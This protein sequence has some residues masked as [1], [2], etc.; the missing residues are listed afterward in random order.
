VTEEKKISYMIAIYGLMQKVLKT[1]KLLDSK[2]KPLKIKNIEMHEQDAIALYDWL[3]QS[4]RKISE[5]KL[6]TQA[7]V[8]NAVAKSLSNE[9]WLNLYLLALFM[10]ESLLEN[11]MSTLDKN[12]LMPK[13]ERMIKHVRK[14]II[15]AN[16]EKPEEGRQTIIDS[17]ICSSNIHRKFSGKAELTKEVREKNRN[18]WKEALRNNRE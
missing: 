14:G 6:N 12:M 5:D 10:T 17:K 16:G 7:Q 2:G 11:D 8:F 9:Y 18:K 1:H 4:L 15:D 3:A 13:V